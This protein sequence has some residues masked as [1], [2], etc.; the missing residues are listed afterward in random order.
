MRDIRKYLFDFWQENNSVNKE[1]WKSLIPRIALLV[2]IYFLL[3]KGLFRITT[4]PFSSYYGDFIYL[5]FLKKMILQIYPVIV[6]LFVLI[7]FNTKLLVKW[8]NFEKGKT[9]RLFIIITTAIL[10]W[11]YSTYDFNLYFNEAHHLDRFLLIITGILIYWRPIFILFFLTSLLTIIGQFEVLSGFSMAT[12]FLLVRILIM[13]LSFFV[14]TLLGRTFRFNDFLFLI[15][16]LVAANYFISGL[17]KLNIEWIMNDHINYLIPT[18]YTNGWLYHMNS[19]SISEMTDFFGWFNIPL[20]IYVI[21]IECGFLFF[22]INLTWGRA[23][24]V[25]AIILHLGIFA[26][27]GI[28]FHMWILILITLLFFI[29]RK[30]Y[31][32]SEEVFNKKYFL[33]GIVLIVGGIL[34][35]SPMRLAWLDVPMNYTYK[36]QAENENGELFE[37]PPNF[38]SPYDYQFTLGNFKYLN[39]EPLLPIVWGTTGTS[40]SISQFFNTQHSN[41]EIFDFEKRRGAIF[42]NDRRKKDFNKFIKQYMFNWNQRPQERVYWHYAKA[43][44]LLWTFP[45]EAFAKEKHKIKRVI[46][47]EVTTYYSETDGYNELRRREISSIP[48]KVN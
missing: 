24:M 43:P 13:F 7:K 5:E 12:A 25:G 46:V 4:I 41:V 17:G 9:V 45:K 3:D 30:K 36:F 2:L 31:I 47:T 40:T 15:V 6:V 37:L 1:S 14:L 39:P 27:S 42:E 35:C 29:F 26:F 23:L 10:T 19:E 11:V 8:S 34:W 16:C 32:H 18:T 20:K 21:L 38:F 22:F 48:I 33:I 28:F 44:R